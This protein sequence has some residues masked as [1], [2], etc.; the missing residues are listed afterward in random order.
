MTEKNCEQC[1]NPLEHKPNESNRDW[2]KRKFC[3]VMCSE[4][5]HKTHGK[6]HKSMY[7]FYERQQILR[8]EEKRET[9]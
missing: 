2:N 3:N 1:G 7:Y 6:W 9:I 4:K 8:T 5:W